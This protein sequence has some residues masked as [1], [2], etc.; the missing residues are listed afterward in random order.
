MHIFIDH[1]T[2]IEVLTITHKVSILLDATDYYRLRELGVTSLSPVWK[3]SGKCSS[4]GFY[5]AGHRH[6]LSR[7]IT[8]CPKHLEVDHINRNPLDN[9]QTNLRCITV[10]QNQLNRNN[11]VKYPGVY[12]N[13]LYRTWRAMAWLNKKHIYLGQFNTPEEASLAYNNYEKLHKIV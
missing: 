8:T 13:K 6:T 7:F 4:V 9:R 10:R 1:K 3:K 12:F 2:H 5:L 11:N